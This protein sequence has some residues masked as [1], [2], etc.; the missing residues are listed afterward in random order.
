MTLETNE[1]IMNLE[2]IVNKINSKGKLTIGVDI[3]NVL[4]HIPIVEHINEVFETDYTYADIQDWSFNNLPDNIRREAMSAF[5]STEF[6]CSTKPYWNNY[7]TLRDWKLQG[8]TLYAIT[9]RSLN[10]IEGTRSQLERH[11]P[12]LFRDFIF[13]TPTDSKAYWLKKI[14]ANV[15]ID[16]WDVE[17]SV[18][19]GIET[20][21]ITNDQTQYNW[22]KRSDT[23]LNQAKSLQHIHLDHSKWLR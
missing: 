15:H 6:M 17:D 16:D 5:K 19:A 12:D 11:Y 14:R 13:V 20:W 8:H 22:T 2:N 23:R 3:D 10:L 21:L 1:K 4:F 7:C 9:R 18:D